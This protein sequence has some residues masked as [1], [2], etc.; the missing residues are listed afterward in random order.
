M[1]QKKSLKKFFY[2]F[3]KFFLFLFL[4]FLFFI[5]IKIF[6]N[7]FLIKNIKIINSEKKDLLGIEEIKKQQ[8]FL[9]NEEEIKNILL[10][11]N[12]D[13][14]DVKIEKK[15]PNS[16]IINIFKDEE[17][18]FLE[19]DIGYFYLSENGKIIFKSKNKKNE[20]LPRINFYQK[21]IFN[22]YLP[23]EKIYFKEI[24]SSLKILKKMNE[25]DVKII[26]IDINGVDMILFNLENEKIFFGVEKDIDFQF[27]QFKKIFTYLKIEG[28]KYKEIDLRFDKP[29]IRF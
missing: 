16:I 7:F 27:F 25:I 2:N 10:R 13:L 22:N 6:F 17:I 12:P 3:F 21:L 18:A 15:Y 5:F 11:K 26:S 9:L 29:I 1:H 28:K 4:S 14:K 24:L 19:A 23:G 8:I 20:S